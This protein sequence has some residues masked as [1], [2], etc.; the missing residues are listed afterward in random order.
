M[1]SSR[2]PASG[3][4]P[5]LEAACAR[6]DRLHADLEAAARGLHQW[7]LEGPAARLRTWSAEAAALA[8]AL[9]ELLRDQNLQ[10]ELRAAAAARQRQAEE[11]TDA[12]ASGEGTGR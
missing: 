6:A 3:P 8:D 11:L 4:D 12:G 7:R 5:R 10:Q 2:P 9:S 1:S